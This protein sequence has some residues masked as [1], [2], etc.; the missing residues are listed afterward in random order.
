MPKRLLCI[1]ATLLLL[2]LSI[3]GMAQELDHSEY[4]FCED[5]PHW[6]PDPYY[7]QYP[8][9]TT[10]PLV[11][12]TGSPL[13]VDGNAVTRDLLFDKHTNKQF[14]TLETR[15][16]N[17]FFLVIDYDKPTDVAGEQFD[18]YFL[19][20]VDEADLMSLLNDEEKED[21]AVSC[22]CKDQ[23]QPG[24]VNTACP[25]CKKDMTECKGIAPTP[26]PKPAPT[27]E[28]EIVPEPV[29]K[30]AGMGGVLLVL[31]LALAGGGAFF[32][33]KRGKGKSQV[34]QAPVYDDDY[35]DDAFDDE[36]DDVDD[37]D[38]EDEV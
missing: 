33:F 19:N 15:K 37:Q 31:V 5:I 32:Y 4:I 25:V 30:G 12:T 35:G 11:V 17:P 21:L 3:V 34:K 28:S 8:A 7:S 26:T 9:A 14:V 29:S 27:P 13:S 16:G 18:T 1:L 22:I 2:C 6:T 24:A 23:C 38:E 10:A 36:D 20:K